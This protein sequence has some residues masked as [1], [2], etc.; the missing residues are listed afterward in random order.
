MKNLILVALFSTIVSS[1]RL[2][3][4][5]MIELNDDKTPQN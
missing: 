3:T 4:F 1:S 5:S 2:D